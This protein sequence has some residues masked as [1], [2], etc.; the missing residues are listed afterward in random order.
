M[1]IDSA[2]GAN[3]LAKIATTADP[4]IAQRTFG[5]A[6]ENIIANAI[7]AITTEGFLLGN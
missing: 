2:L 6:T 1:Y 5:I 4:D 3:P 7:G